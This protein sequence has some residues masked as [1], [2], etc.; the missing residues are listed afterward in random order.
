M[1]YDIKTIFCALGHSD[2]PIAHDTLEVQ[3]A[4]SIARLLRKILKHQ[5]DSESGPLQRATFAN[6]SPPRLSLRVRRSQK[7]LGKPHPIR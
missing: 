6:R 7:A 3:A 2:S 5:F 1:L 4:S